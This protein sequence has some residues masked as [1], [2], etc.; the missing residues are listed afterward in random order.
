MSEQL[1]A[2]LTGLEALVERLVDEKVRAAL[3][4][5]GDGWLTSDEAAQYLGI[6]RST[7]HDLVCDGRLP[8]HG[9]K[10]HR[11]RFRREDLDAYARG[12]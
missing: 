1:I 2:E 10:G 3:A 4:G 6:A 11:L 8:R 5:R 9:E 7:L 12:D